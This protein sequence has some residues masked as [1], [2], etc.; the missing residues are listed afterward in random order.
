MSKIDRFSRRTLLRALGLGPA[1]LPLLQVEQARGDV[2][3]AKGA[4]ILVWANGWISQSAASGWPDPGDNFAFKPFQAAL[5]PL[6]NDLILLDNMN[7]RF[8]RDSKASENTGHACFQ[9]MLTGELYQAPGTSTAGGVAG[10]PSIDQHIGAALAKAGLPRPAELEPGRL[11]QE[12][13]ALVV[14]GRWRSR[15]ARDRSVQGLF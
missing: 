1:L 13:S 14:A 12:P 9:G 2:P 5:E 7:Y 15:R 3:A 10:G 6:R 8:L 4:L 11:H